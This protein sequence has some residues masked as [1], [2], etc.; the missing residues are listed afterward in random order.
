M[1]PS[2]IEDYLVTVRTD[3]GLDLVTQTIKFMQIL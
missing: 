1:R 3:N 2:H